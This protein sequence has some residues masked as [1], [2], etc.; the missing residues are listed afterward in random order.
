[1]T[2]SWSGNWKDNIVFCLCIY[3]IRHESSS[4][5]A[6]SYGRFDYLIYKCLCSFSNLTGAANLRVFTV[7][8]TDVLTAMFICV[9]LRYL[10]PRFINVLNVAQTH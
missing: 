7:L 8:F 3:Y 10:A 1:M 6:F 5:F 4:L 9:S 2:K